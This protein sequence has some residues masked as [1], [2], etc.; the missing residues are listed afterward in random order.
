MAKTV[1]N[2]NV[3]KNIGNFLGVVDTYTD[4]SSLKFDTY[5]FAIVKYN[6]GINLEGIYKVS[7]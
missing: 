5:D 4:L 7:C 3:L 1:L 6:E 2:L